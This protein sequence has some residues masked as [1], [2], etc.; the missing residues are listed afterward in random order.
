MLSDAY[1]IAIQRE[2]GSRTGRQVALSTIYAT[3]T[4]LEARGYEGSPAPA[5]RASARTRVSGPRPL[6][7]PNRGPAPT[8]APAALLSLRMRFFHQRQ[9]VP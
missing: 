6:A 2:I 1:G 9:E 8:P 4:R 3:L 5:H 7:L